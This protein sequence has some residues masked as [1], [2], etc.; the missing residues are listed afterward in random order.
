[1]SKEPDNYSGQVVL[2]G[3]QDW[4]Q[5]VLVDVGEIKNMTAN[6]RHVGSAL[7][8]AQNAGSALLEVKRVTKLEYPD[9]ITAKPQ[10]IIPAGSP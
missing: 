6:L 9:K 7:P 8:E 2:G 4:V 3:Y 1:L 5:D 10:L